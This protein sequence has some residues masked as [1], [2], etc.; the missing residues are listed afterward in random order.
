VNDL[1]RALVG[2]YADVC[3][4][5]DGRIQVRA[6]GVALPHSTLSPERRITHAAITENK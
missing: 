6:N 2:K 3:E 4:M 5:A 1:T